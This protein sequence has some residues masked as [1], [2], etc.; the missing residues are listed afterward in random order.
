MTSAV[1]A[2]HAAA[3]A[4]PTRLSLGQARGGSIGTALLST[5][6]LGTTASCRA[7]QSGLA[8]PAAGRV[9][10]YSEA[11]GARA[12]ILAT[13]AGVPALMIDTARP[14]AKTRPP[15]GGRSQ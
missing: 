9:H 3:S 14:D 4:P 8:T 6:A 2:P 5:I 7:L 12:A 13:A 11:A 1:A 15:A 10:G